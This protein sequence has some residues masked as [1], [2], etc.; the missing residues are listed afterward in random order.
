DDQPAPVR[1]GVDEPA[2]VRV[3]QTAAPRSAFPEGQLRA[4]AEVPDI[5]EPALPVAR[6]VHDAQETSVGAELARSV[7]EA[8][9]RVGQ[10]NQLSAIC[11]VTN[12]S[13]LA[14]L[15]GRRIP[16][17]L[18]ITARAMDQPGLM[19]AVRAQVNEPQRGQ[20][21]G[22]DLGQEFPPLGVIA[23]L[24]GGAAEQVEAVE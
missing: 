18:A 1:I 15:H 12:D 14:G 8:N 22:A 3:Q 24:A 16:L 4:V 10:A 2:T 6:F 20:G 11:P 9:A 23:Q 13:L 17:Q 19:F 5:D 7:P 21:P